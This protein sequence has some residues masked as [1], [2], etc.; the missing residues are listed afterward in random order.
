MSGCTW[1]VC[2]DL[3]NLWQVIELASVNTSE[4]YV[5]RWSFPPLWIWTSLVFHIFKP[6]P[7]NIYTN[8]GVWAFLKGCPG[9]WRKSY[10]GNGKFIGFCVKVL[11][12]LL[13]VCTNYTYIDYNS[14]STQRNWLVNWFVLDITCVYRHPPD[15]RRHR[16]RH[17]LTS[18]PGNWRGQRADVACFCKGH[19]DL[20]TSFTN[21]PLYH[22]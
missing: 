10:I 15:F 16:H 6:F 8:S 7:L 9:S 18:E 4:R 21:L 14:C 5:L 2:D 20:Q 1:C 22:T 12:N 19:M 17:P 11:F 3:L 13:D